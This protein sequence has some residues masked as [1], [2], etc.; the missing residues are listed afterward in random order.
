MADNLFLLRGIIDH[1]IYLNTSIHLTFYDFKQCFDSIW[2]KHSMNC[3]WDAGVRNELFYLIYLL[4]KNANII[5]RTPFGQTEE[6]K[7]KNLVKQ[8]TCLGPTSCG[9]STGQ[10]CTENTALIQEFTLV[11]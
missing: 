2:L 4:N 11:Q 10:Y 8:G 5:V 7:V 9:I 6:F 1:T 3:M